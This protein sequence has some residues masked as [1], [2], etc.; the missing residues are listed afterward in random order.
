M[1]PLH[2]LSEPREAQSSFLLRSKHSLGIFKVDAFFPGYSIQRHA[3]EPSRFRTF[4]K[5]PP[6]GCSAIQRAAAARGRGAA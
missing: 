4:E 5:E 3:E 2:E 6:Y 1:I